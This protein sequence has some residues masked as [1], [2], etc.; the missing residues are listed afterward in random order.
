MK[1]N[2]EGNKYS[3]I[4]YYTIIQLT[5]N[6]Q[7]PLI[8]NYQIYCIDIIRLTFIHTSPLTLH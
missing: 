1:T 4:F 7:Q 5:F 6:I 2:Q 3:I 8:S